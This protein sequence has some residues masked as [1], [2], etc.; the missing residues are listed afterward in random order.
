MKKKKTQAAF[1]ISA[2]LEVNTLEA[3]Q[4]SVKNLEPLNQAGALE[5]VWA[6]FGSNLSPV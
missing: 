5:Q 1:F 6:L 4:S 3:P 2:W